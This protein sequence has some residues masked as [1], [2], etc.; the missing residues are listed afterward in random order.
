MSEQVL[1]PGAQPWS[2]EG[3]DDRGHVGVI[4]T[5]GFTS[6]PNAT[7]PLG[8]R[9]NREG[10]AVEVLLLPGHGTT[11]R[12]M[13][14][15]RYLDWRDHLEGVLDRLLDRVQ[16]V[17]L[18]GHSLGGT[19][20]LDVASRR[21]SDVAGI[22]PINAQVLAPQQPLARV[23]PVLQHLVPYVPRDLAGLPTND[24][25]KPDA[26]ERAYSM[27][28]A[29][30]AQSLIRELPRIRAQLSDVTQPVL[31]VTSP[32]DHTVPADN[33]AAL[34]QLLGSEDVTEL[35]CERSY[36]VATIDWDQERIEDAVTAFVDRVTGTAAS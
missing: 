18:V 11:V 30:P 3:D 16:Q 4:V 24:I 1:I 29:K 2:A 32:Q 10:Y 28:P 9:L 5:H 8:E 20:S 13:G 25:A 15:T 12:D 6:N 21:R 27:V 17:V 33:G 23:A 22:V 35:V 26:T 19:L 31:I 36:H 14:R 7:R 34:K